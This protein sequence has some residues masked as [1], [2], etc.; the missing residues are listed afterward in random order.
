[1]AQKGKKAKMAPMRKKHKP[2]SVVDTRAKKMQLAIW[3]GELRS[4]REVARLFKETYGTYLDHHAV[5]RFAHS[6]KNAPLIAYLK[7]S[8]VENLSKIPIA[9]KAV[10]LR[11]AQAVYEE[12]M[13]ERQTGETLSGEPLFS[14]DT[15]AALGA[16]KEAREELSKKAPVLL[17]QKNVFQDIKVEGVETDELINFINKQLSSQ[18]AGE[19]RV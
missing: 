11:Y 16:I 19:R 17:F 1:M 8:F 4:Y 10:R 18:V 6:K 9:N 12:A 2:H 15:K 5:W 13:T 3:L 7:R 14:V